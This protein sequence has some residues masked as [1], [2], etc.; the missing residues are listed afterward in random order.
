MKPFH[1]ATKKEKEND[2]A[3]DIWFPALPI[4]FFFLKATGLEHDITG[5]RGKRLK[6]AEDRIT[7][8]VEYRLWDMMCIGKTKGHG[9]RYT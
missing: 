6:V 3:S 8:T 4:S 9:R 2:K 5:K 1:V 7:K